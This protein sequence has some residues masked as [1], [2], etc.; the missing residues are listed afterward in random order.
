MTDRENVGRE[1]KMEAE[2]S[3]DAIQGNSSN[4]NRRR[5]HRRGKRRGH[6]RRT[7]SV[8][9]AKV[10]KSVCEEVLKDELKSTKSELKIVKES[11]ES[12]F[13]GKKGRSIM[14]NSYESNLAD[15]Q[16]DA[17]NRTLSVKKKRH[18]QQRNIKKMYKGRTKNTHR[19]GLVS[20]SKMLILRPDRGSLMNAPRNSTQFIIDDHA[21]GPYEGPHSP[22]I[23]QEKMQENSNRSRYSRS[24]NSNCTDDFQSVLDDDPFS[25]DY[26]ER[27]FQTA[28][29]SAHREDVSTWDKPKLI[30]KITDLEKRH[31]DLLSK[32]SGN[33]QE[34]HLRNLQSKL[35]SKQQENNRL[36]AERKLLFDIDCNQ[37][38][39]MKPVAS[40]ELEEPAVKSKQFENEDF[41]VPS[42]S[43][44]LDTQRSTTTLIKQRNIVGM[45]ADS[46]NE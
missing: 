13:T 28:Y 5:H 33:D 14:P 27:D 39:C 46:T 2:G 41:D 29:E 15:F 11:D 4:Y 24:T 44:I 36:K 9:K 3:E 32:L 10:E 37:I 12:S 34:I 31:K 18:P 7:C 40:T 22:C 43:N 16:N 38:Q 17:S 20:K 30:Q 35:V 21:E 8:D 45:V 6:R 23:L 25:A 19:A 26:L 1:E 42:Q